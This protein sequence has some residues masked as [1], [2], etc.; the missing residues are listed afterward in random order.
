MT[1]PKSPR[2]WIEHLVAEAFDQTRTP[3]S[4]EYKAGLRMLLT[5]RFTL[6]PMTCQYKAGTASY[7]AFF[8]GVHEGC[9]IWADHIQQHRRTA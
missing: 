2:E 5:Q 3:R 1:T 7:D 4:E 8:A 6:K 9:S